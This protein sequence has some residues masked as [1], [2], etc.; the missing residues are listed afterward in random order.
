MTPRPE[1]PLH[2]PAHTDGSTTHAAAG[3]PDGEPICPCDARA[4]GRGGPHRP[5]CCRA[6]NL[7]DTTTQRFLVITVLLTTAV[8]LTIWFRLDDIRER[9]LEQAATGNG[10]TAQMA[11]L[12]V[13]ADD[14][15]V[16]QVQLA[17]SRLNDA[18]WGPGGSEARNAA[19]EQLSRAA[20][21]APAIG[22]SDTEAME[23][24]AVRDAC[25]DEAVRTVAA[26]N[27]TQG[28]EHYLMTGQGRE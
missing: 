16:A 22:Y 25:T 9:I 2:H 4:F 14:A 8:A 1:P 12:A 28:L 19:C 20:K 17:H 21:L 26:H 15:V 6:P 27:A 13:G 3:D 10:I 11:G 18:A 5:D 24:L 7:R 23:I